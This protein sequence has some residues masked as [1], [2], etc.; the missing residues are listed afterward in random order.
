MTVRPD[1][2]TALPDAADQSEDVLAL[3]ADFLDQ[4]AVDAHRR[5]GEVAGVALTMADHA[6]SPLT[7]GASTE[8]ARAVDELQYRIGFG[9]CLNALS[10]GGE[11][12]GLGAR[13]ASLA[14]P[15]VAAVDFDPWGTRR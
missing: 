5:L 7:I 10:G 2:A 9:P 11:A 1:G 8:L 6:G 15:F 3:I 4:L 13:A 12:R 14:R